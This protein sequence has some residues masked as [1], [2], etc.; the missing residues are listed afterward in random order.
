MRELTYAQALNEA[1]REEM[2]RDENVILLGEDIAG[3]GGAFKVTLGLADQFGPKRVRNT[4]L[5]EA[6]IAGS[7]V[8]A[9]LTGLRPVCEIMYIDFITIA[10][11]QIVN[12]AAKIYYMSGGQA[13][14][15][16]TLR[17]QGGGGRGNAAQ[18]SQCLEAWLAHIP[19]LIVV[20]PAT[21]YDAKGLLKSAIRNDNPVIFIEHKSLYTT[22]GEVPEEEYLIELGQAEIKRK[23]GDMTIIATSWMVPRAMEAAEQLSGQGIEAE[24]VDPRTLVP[25]DEETIISSVK[26]TGRVVV[27][28]EA[29][30]RCGFGAELAALIQEEAFDYLDAPVA[31]VANPNV[32]VPFAPQLEK[33]I[34]PDVAKI[35]AAAKSLL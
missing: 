7:A 3:H 27:V 4:P 26:K 17:T 6:V 31:R 13:K 28:H 35:V 32:P 33:A 9:A 18:H 8:G 1:L 5:A 21:P 34:I 19:G 29:Y 20:Q 15:P 10:L 30:R 2:L 24:V 11:D 25:L 16:M 22:R 12:Q 23:G 14:V